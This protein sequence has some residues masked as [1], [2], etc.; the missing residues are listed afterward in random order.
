MFFVCVIG[1]AGMFSHVEHQHI[2]FVAWCKMREGAAAGWWAFYIKKNIRIV[3][4]MTHERTTAYITQLKQQ[5][6]KNGAITF[7]ARRH[8]V[9]VLLSNGSF[10]IYVGLVV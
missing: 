9:N 2:C 10:L 8:N 6:A 7:A 5:K 3:M 1:F 4:C